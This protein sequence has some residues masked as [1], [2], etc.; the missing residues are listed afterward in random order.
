MATSFVKKLFENPNEII[1][2]ITKM[3]GK[4]QA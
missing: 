3:S 4:I 2:R 1:L